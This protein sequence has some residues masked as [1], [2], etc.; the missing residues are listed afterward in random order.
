MEI[1]TDKVISSESK[2]KIR[3]Y[4]KKFP[5][6]PLTGIVFKFQIINPIKMV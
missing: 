3:V 1:N 2:N 5:G 4:K 6:S